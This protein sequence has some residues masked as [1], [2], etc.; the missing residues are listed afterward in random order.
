LN[1]V[2]GRNLGIEVFLIFTVS[3]VRGLRPTRALRTVFSKEPKPL[4]ATFSPRA[5]ARVMVST[6]ASTASV[7]SFLLP[8]R[9]SSA[10]TS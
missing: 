1:A 6:I 7:A 5:T 4:I 2:P 9:P 10:S 3:P 8:S